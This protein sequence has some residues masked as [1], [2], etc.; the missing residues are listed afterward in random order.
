VLGGRLA[1]RFLIGCYGKVLELGKQALRITE[2]AAHMFPD[3]VVERLAV[4]LGAWARRL[5][6]GQRAVSAAAPIAV[7]PP[8]RR[9]GRAAFTHR[10]MLARPQ[11]ASTRQL[12]LR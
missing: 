5:A 4:H 8:A 11:A 2:Q 1:G 7:T 3:R 12:Y 6:G 10:T 9:I